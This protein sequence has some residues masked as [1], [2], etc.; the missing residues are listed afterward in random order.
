MLFAE[1][2]STCHGANARGGLKDLRWMSAET[3]AQFLDIV[4]RGIRTDK[5]MASFADIITE[6]QA[7][8]IHQYL[9]ARANEDWADEAT[10]SK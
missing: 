10:K 9:I 8:S 4:L 1:K 5:G 7:E 6:Q 2:C 3:H